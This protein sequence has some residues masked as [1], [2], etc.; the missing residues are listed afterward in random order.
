[1]DPSSWVRA[2]IDLSDSV[3]DLRIE[4]LL[5]RSPG[6]SRSDVVRLVLGDGTAGIESK[7]AVS[8]ASFLAFAV[9]RLT[10]RAFRSR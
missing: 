8:P 6:W 9:I 7:P 3:R 1:M 4:G 10:T 2:A 5:L